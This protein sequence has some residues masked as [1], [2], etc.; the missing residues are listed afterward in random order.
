MVILFYFPNYHLSFGEPRELFIHQAN[1]LH[2]LIHQED[3]FHH[4]ICLIFSKF[5]TPGQTSTLICVLRRQEI[6]FPRQNHPPLA[7]THDG[8]LHHHS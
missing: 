3:P 6:F 1:P 5:R 4:L 8:P 7:D 2:S